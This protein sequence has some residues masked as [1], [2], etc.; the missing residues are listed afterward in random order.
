VT[1]LPTSHPLAHPDDPRLAT[2]LARLAQREARAFL[3]LK[4]SAERS[5]G[6][7]PPKYR[8]LISIA[9]GL[10]TQCSYCIDAHTERAV[11]AGATRE[12]LAETVF[13]VAALRA[14]AAALAAA[15]LAAGAALAGVA[16]LAAGVAAFAVALA[17]V[18]R[19][20][21]AGLVPLA[22]AARLRAAGSPLASPGR[23]RAWRR[24]CP[25]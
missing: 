12:E 2:E 22:S 14:G 10:T 8:E 9:V 6:S 11:A 13:I 21:G 17:A 15:A 1:K 5:D 18:L 25:V 16:A 20:A 3:E 19:A 24:N 7:I 4:A 23:P